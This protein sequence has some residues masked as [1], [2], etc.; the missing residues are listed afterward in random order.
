MLLFEQVA[1][2]GQQD[3]GSGYWVVSQTRSLTSCS[4][5]LSCRF[6]TRTWAVPFSSRVRY[7][8]CPFPQLQFWPC[9]SAND[10]LR[11]TPQLG[12]ALPGTCIWVLKAQPTDHTQNRTALAGWGWLSSSVWVFIQMAVQ[13]WMWIYDNGTFWLYATLDHSASFAHAMQLWHFSQE[14]LI[15]EIYKHKVH[16]YTEK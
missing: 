6:R 11:A 1:R 12:L 14:Y 4:D 16:W 15:W 2:D 8:P 10:P 7:Y 9:S 5:P 3:M 13:P